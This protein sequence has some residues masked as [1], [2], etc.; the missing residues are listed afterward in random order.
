MDDL[1]ESMV[2][3]QIIRRGVKDPK[4]LDAL[5]K[6]QRHLFVP[7]LLNPNPFFIRNRTKNGT[8]F[9]GV[10]FYASGN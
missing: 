8:R 5:R 7:E 3:T 9:S 4:V 10:I 2:Q 6:V 1:R